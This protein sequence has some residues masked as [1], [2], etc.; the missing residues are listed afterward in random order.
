MIVRVLWAASIVL[1]FVYMTLPPLS[2]VVF[3]LRDR[4]ALKR[5]VAA[6]WIGG[7]I[8][9]AAVLSAYVV[10][11]GGLPPYSQIGLAI[12]LGA[13]IMLLLKS[14]DFLFRSLIARVF[15]TRVVDP[16][17]PVT[18]WRIWLAG[19][20]R[21]L[22]FA[23]FALP[24]V[25]AAVM[26]YRPRVTTSDTPSSV[27]KASYADATLT[28]RDGVRIAA[29]YVPAERPSETTVV[30]LHG[31]GS[32]RTGMWMLMKSLREA[33]MNVVAIDFRAHGASAGQLCTFGALEREDVLAAIDWVSVNH[34]S[35]SKR[36]FLVGASLGG[37][38]GLGAAAIDERVSGVVVLGTFD[39]LA[40][41]STDISSKHLPRPIGWLT[42]AF[43]LPI[44]SLHTGVN[45]SAY[46]PRDDISKVWPRPV[47]IVHGAHDEIIP[48][49]HGKR[50]FDAA[51][52]PRDCYFPAGSHNGVLED[53]SVIDRVIYFIET[54]TRSPII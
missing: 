29:W 31:L 8:V 37:A 9:S 39:S 34:A 14:I 24:W 45:L 43:G 46:A 20:V 25:M 35:D 44:A 11:V 26:V 3:F 41:L 53:K 2:L 7:A 54:A 6:G 17:K 22:V 19:T 33:G 47:M 18:R 42:N 13:A 38:A 12:Y 36:L 40:Q 27:L 30:L 48:Y 16:E 21:I 5:Q 49:E 15:R 23:S 28:T 50:L 51:Y 1:K 10:G 4:S 52:A 32:N